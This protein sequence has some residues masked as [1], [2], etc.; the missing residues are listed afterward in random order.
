MDEKLARNQAKTVVTTGSGENKSIISG[1]PQITSQTAK[2]VTSGNMVDLVFVIDTTGSMDNKI[3]ALLSTC[4]Q[5]VDEA[6]KM[7]L[8]MQFALVSFG[9]ISVQGGGDKIETIVP[10]TGEVE[11]MKHGLSHI[12]RNNGFGNQGETCLEAVQEAFKISHRPKAVKVLVLITDEPAII[13]N[14][15]PAGITNQLSQKEYLAFVIATDEPYYK[16]MAVKNGGIWKQIGTSTN[17]SEI[18]ALFRELAKKVS[19][20]AKNVHLI[21]KGSVREYLK[22]NPPD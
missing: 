17:L 10:L 20:I 18:L 12:P 15:T 22:L 11:R 1:K 4:S 16:E 19:Q 14:L 21:G 2:V 7:Q 6:S 8:D 3:E 9:D 13:G 5:F